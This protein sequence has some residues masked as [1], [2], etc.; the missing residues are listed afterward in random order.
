M[1]IMW[2]IPQIEIIHIPKRQT[3]GENK[4][5]KCALLGIKPNIVYEIYCSSKYQQ[6]AFWC[7]RINI[8]GWVN[9]CNF[10]RLVGR[11]ETEM[12]RKFGVQF[13]QTHN[14]SKRVWS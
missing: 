13:D 12:L 8:H 4:V 3:G 6:L 5:Q 2:L 9:E 10:E 7:E 11:T 14:F 1:Y